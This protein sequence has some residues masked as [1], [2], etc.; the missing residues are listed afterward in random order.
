MSKVG[1]LFLLAFISIILFTSI[2]SL[3]ES[4]RTIYYWILGVFDAIGIGFILRNLI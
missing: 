4:S 2:Q 3:P 1:K